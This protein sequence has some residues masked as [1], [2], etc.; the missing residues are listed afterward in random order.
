VD[1]DDLNMP[2]LLD[3]SIYDEIKSVELIDHIKRAGK[4]SIAESHKNRLQFF[5]IARNEVARQSKRK[6]IHHEGA[7][8]TKKTVIRSYAV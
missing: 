6:D 7:K 8:T 2:Y 3:V 1:L 4:N 5:V